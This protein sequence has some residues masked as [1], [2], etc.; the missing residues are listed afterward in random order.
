MAQNNKVPAAHT[1]RKLQGHNEANHKTQENRYTSPVDEA[2]VSADDPDVLQGY[3]DW[4]LNNKHSAIF[5]DLEK[6]EIANRP[7]SLPILYRYLGCQ[8]PIRHMYNLNK[9]ALTYVYVFDSSPDGC[10][11][12]NKLEKA[13]QDIPL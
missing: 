11:L 13:H 10:T 8:Y 1:T 12:A 5:K 9:P 4:S 7:P 3:P 6:I 2:R